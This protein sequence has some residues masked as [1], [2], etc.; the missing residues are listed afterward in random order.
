MESCCKTRKTKVVQRTEWDEEIEHR[1]KAT[2]Q[3]IRFGLAYR[4]QDD[5]Q[6]ESERAGLTTRSLATHAAASA[7]RICSSTTRKKDGRSTSARRK[8]RSHVHAR[9]HGRSTTSLPQAN[10]A[11]S[12]HRAVFLQPGTRLIPACGRQ[13]FGILTRYRQYI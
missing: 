12:D 9:S 1:I 13:P 10:L 6:E 8:P 5:C 2:I 4:A 3:R 7:I 11:L